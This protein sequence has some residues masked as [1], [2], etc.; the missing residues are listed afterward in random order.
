MAS[1]LVRTLMEK[2]SRKRRATGDTAAFCTYV[3]LQI[4][5]ITGLFPRRET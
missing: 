3:A 1:W 4:P 5:K 2:M